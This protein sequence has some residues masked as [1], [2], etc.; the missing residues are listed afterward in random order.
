MSFTDR[1]VIETRGLTKRFA[2][3]RAVDG[4]TSGSRM[5]KARAD[6]SEQ[7][8]ARLAD[9]GQFLPAVDARARFD[10]TDATRLT[11]EW[12]PLHRRGQLTTGV[13]ARPH[14]GEA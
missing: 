9:W 6:V 7:R 8:A 11:F 10:R 2:D 4:W 3:T 14:A 12:S 1:A 13:G 5:A